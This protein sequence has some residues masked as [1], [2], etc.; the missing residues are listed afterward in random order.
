MTDSSRARCAAKSEEGAFF[1]SG[2][3]CK[4]MSY[5]LRRVFECPEVDPELSARHA[6]RSSQFTRIILAVNVPRNNKVNDKKNC[7]QAIHI[8]TRP[9]GTR[10]AE[11]LLELETAASSQDSI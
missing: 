4:V 10:T 9:A 11:K 8:K 3:T 1:R 7:T 5:A 2:E 6:I